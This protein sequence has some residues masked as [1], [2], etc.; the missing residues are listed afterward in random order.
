ME[1]QIQALK[2]KATLFRKRLNADNTLSTTELFRDWLDW[3]LMK[4]LSWFLSPTSLSILTTVQTSFF[5]LDPHSSWSFYFYSDKF[6]DDARLINLASSSAFELF[7][8]AAKEALY[9][10]LSN[11]WWALFLDLQIESSIE[12][13]NILFALWILLKTSVGAIEFIQNDELGYPSRM[14]LTSQPV[15]DS[16]QSPSIRSNNPA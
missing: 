5:S 10:K 15:G 8:S 16:T 1:S 2:V 6:D 9:T 3:D 11:N 13:P 12:I 14:H 7:A 4:T